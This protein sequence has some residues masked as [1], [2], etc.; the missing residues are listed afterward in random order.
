[1]ALSQEAAYEVL[2]ELCYHSRQ[3]LQDVADKLITWHHTSIESSEWE[4]MPPVE[5]R[6]HSGMSYLHSVDCTVCLSH[7][8]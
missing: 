8:G 4:Y 1:M 7:L 3:C 2:V 6:A 5:G